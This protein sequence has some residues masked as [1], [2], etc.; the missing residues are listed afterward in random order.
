MSD[1]QR[2]V[3]AR[4]SQRMQLTLAVADAI[5][6]AHLEGRNMHVITELP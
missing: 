6:P 3:H 4:N 2:P 5:V 1:Q